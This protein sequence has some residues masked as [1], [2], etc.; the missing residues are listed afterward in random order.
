MRI[1]IEGFDGRDRARLDLPASQQ[2]LL[3]AVAATGK[4]VI[5]ISL[6]G[7]ALALTW[8]KEHAAAVL[9]AW[10][11]GVGGGTAIARTLAGVNNPAGRLPLTLHVSTRDLPTFTDYA[12]KNPTYPH[13][14]GTPLW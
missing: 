3:E 9:Q 8:A 5:V 12:L 2:R 4:P 7:S 13:Y 10:Y 6:S 14:T 11:P 1:K